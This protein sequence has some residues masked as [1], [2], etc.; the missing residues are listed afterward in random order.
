LCTVAAA[1]GDAVLARKR[2]DEAARFFWTGGM[3]WNIQQRKAF[4]QELG[5][6]E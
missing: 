5:S 4:L 1:Q 6:P 2:A 3:G